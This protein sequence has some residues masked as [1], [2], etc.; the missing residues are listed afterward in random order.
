MKKIKIELDDNLG[1]LIEDAAKASNCTPQEIIEGLLYARLAENCA[2]QEFYKNEP[3]PEFITQNNKLML[4]GQELFKTVFEI[5]KAEITELQILRALFHE[6]Q[7]E[8]I[9]GGNA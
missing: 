3:A 6:L 4:S 5:R 1:N 2:R 9:K 7:T 8:T